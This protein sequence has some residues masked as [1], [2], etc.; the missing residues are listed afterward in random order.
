MPPP[1]ELLLIGA[2]GPAELRSNGAF[3]PDV[4]SLTG[5]MDEN[6]LNRAGFAGGSEP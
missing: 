6:Q 3:V 5:I 1:R 4:I 2:L